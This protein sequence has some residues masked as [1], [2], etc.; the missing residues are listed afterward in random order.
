MSL[1]FWSYILMG[2]IDNKQNDNIYIYILLDGD[3]YCGGKFN[4][5]EQRAGNKGLYLLLARAS[6][7]RASRLKKDSMQT[8]RAGV[9]HVWETEGT[10]VGQEPRELGSDRKY[11]RANGCVSGGT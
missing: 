11:L 6:V 9:W 1:F 4:K 5:W 10:L 8:C 2:V 7:D 3:K